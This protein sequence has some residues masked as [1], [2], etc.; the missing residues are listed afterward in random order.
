M[1]QGMRVNVLSG[2]PQKWSRDIFVTDP[3]GKVY[4]GKIHKVSSDAA[5]VVRDADIVLLCVP[6]YMIESTL[7]K[8]KPYISDRCMVGSIVSSTGFFFIAHEIYGADVE[9]FGFQR[10]P[11]I[12]RQSEYGKSGELLGYKPSL[13]VV[14][15]NSRDTEQ[16]RALL[17]QLFMTP[18][19]LLDNYYEASLTN[20]NPLLH[21]SRL[22][23]MWGRGVVMPVKERTL[24]YAD[25]TDDAS[26]Y[27]IRMDNEFQRLLQDLGIREGVI[28]TILSYYESTDVMSL[29][30]KIRSIEA[31]KSI[32]APMNMVDGGWVPDYQNRYFTEDFPYGLKYIYDLAKSRGISCPTIEEVYNWGISVTQQD[33]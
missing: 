19:K 18:I 12:A 26:D 9:L 20:S 16:S 13:N 31:F 24:F 23:S 11:F 17:E 6:G 7:S 28:P 14:I 5:D 33:A 30:S 4:S 8:V 21:T 2:H 15:E 27:L 32:P 22:Y 29:T 1:A 3:E 25:W 10:V